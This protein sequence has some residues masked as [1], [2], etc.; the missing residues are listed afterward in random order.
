MRNI[1]TGF[2]VLGTLAMGTMLP[3]AAH[4]L[5]VPLP[6]GHP[7]AVQPADWDGDRCGPRCWEQRREA[8]ERELEHERWAQHQR[9]EEHRRWEES[10]R[11]PPAPAYD[12]HYHY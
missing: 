9:W 1:L 11:Y 4:P 10:H 6:V 8:R 7:A 2:A 12:Y 5:S 3:A